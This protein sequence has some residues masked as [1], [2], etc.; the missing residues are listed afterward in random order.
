MPLWP[1]YAL[2]SI[3]LLL[4][5]A[6][7][8]SCSAASCRSTRSGSTGRSSR[9]SATNGAQP[10]W[11]LGWLIGALRLMPRFESTFAG[12]SIVPNPFFGG[13]LFPT[14]VF[15]AL[16][17]WPALERRFTGDHERHDL[18]DLPRTPLRTALGAAFF[19]WVSCD[20][21]RRLRGQDPRQCQRLLHGS[22]W[23]FRVAALLVPLAVFLATRAI[24]RE[25]AASGT[26]P[27]R[28]WSGAVLARAP[29]GGFVALDGGGRG[30]PGPADASEP[31]AASK[32]ATGEAAGRM[33]A[34][35]TFGLML[36]A[37]ARRLVAWRR[38]PGGGQA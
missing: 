35:F 8:S 9:G 36:A 26:H 6:G 12:K 5:V 18:L 27:L 30:V 38:P 21:H 29:D 1:G 11:Y 24:C 3:A 14:V 25:L 10:D 37:A 28:G 31:V 2:R 23:I 15:A 16:L 33:T 17:A 19:S 7:L 13:L 22:V 20:L 4:S 34:A 32:P